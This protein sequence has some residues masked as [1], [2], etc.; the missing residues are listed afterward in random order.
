ME[1]AP[2]APFQVRLR[3]QFADKKAV[4]VSVFKPEADE[5]V[6]L[7]FT[8]QGSWITFTAPASKIYSM[9][10]VSYQ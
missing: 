3:K 10:V 9:V 1:K 7:Q 4:S 5:P 8:E 2:L 6:K